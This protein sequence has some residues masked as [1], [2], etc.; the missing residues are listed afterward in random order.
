MRG[1][2]LVPQEWHRVAADRIAELLI[3]DIGTQQKKF[4]ISVAGESGAGKSEVAL[5]L[6]DALNGYGISSCILQ[7][8]DYFVYPP[9]TNADMRIK[10]IRHIGLSEVRLELLD[11]HLGDFIVGKGMIKKPLVIFEDNCITAETLT[12][13]RIRVMIVE[14]TYTTILKNLNGRIFIDRTYEDTRE[15]RIRRNR[16]KQD[17]FLEKVLRIEHDIISN[18]KSAADIVIT[19]DHEVRKIDGPR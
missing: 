17:D 10:D 3:P 9:R 13:E 1:D 2:K 14:G 18:H 4:T 11:Q 19:R 8:D 15:T 6:A 7:Q 16:E 12:V 5:A